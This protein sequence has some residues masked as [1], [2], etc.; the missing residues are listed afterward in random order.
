MTATFDS[1]GNVYSGG[2]AFSTGY[3]ATIGAYQQN[4]AGGIGIGTG[5]YAN[6]CD[7]AIIKYSPD[8]VSRL[9][10]TY[11]GGGNGEEL[12]HSLVCDAFDNLLIFGTTGSNDFPT[13]Q[14]AYD[15]TFNGGT[16]VTYD[17]VILF[18]NGTDIYVS[19]ISEDGTQ[20]IASTYI[21]GSKNDGFNFRPNYA[22]EIMHGNDSL[23]YNYADGARGEVIAD[24]KYNVYVGTCT[25]SNDFPTTQNAFQQ[26]SN[27]K[28]EGIVFKLDQNLSNLIF[29]SY[30]GG[31]QDDAIYSIDVGINDDVY[32]AG[33]TSSQDLYTSSNAYKQTYQGGTTDGFVAHISKFGDQII[34][35][36]YFGS[37]NYDQAYFVRLDKTNNIYITGQTKATGNTLIYNAI[38]NTPNSGQFITKLTNNL[39]TIYWSTVFGTGIGK[40][41]ISITAFAVDICNRIY[42]SGWGRE[43]ALHDG[44]T[45]ASIDGTKNMD[46]TPGAY[47]STTDGQDF[48]IMVMADDASYLDYASFFGEQYT[49]GYSGHDHVDGGTS[50]FDNKGN[51]Y[52]SI[53]ASC[54]GFQDFPTYPNPGV[55]S[56]NNNSS[57]C[58]NAVFRFSFADDFSLADF[59]IPPVGCTPYNV[60]FNN[61][62]TG[63]VHYV[64]D[65]GDGSPLS[66]DINPTHTYTNSGIYLVTL[67][68][69]D[70]SSCNL[71]DTVTKQIQVLSNSTDTITDVSICLNQAQQIG[72]APNGNPNINYTWYPSTGLS[73]TTVANP[74]ANPSDTTTYVLIISNGVCGD[75]LY[76]TVNV[77]KNNVSI[78]A[79][80]D[81]TICKGSQVNLFAESNINSGYYIWST[82]N[83]FNDT[84]NSSLNDS[85]LN[86]SINNQT[87]LYVKINESQCNYTAYDSVLINLYPINAQTSNDTTICLNDTINIWAFNTI[88]NDTLIYNWNGNNII[89][90]N[91]SNTATIN[92][93][94]NTSYILWYQN[95]HG[96]SNTD[97][98]NVNVE[99]IFF[100]NDSIIDNKCYGD[101][102]GEIYVSVSASLPYN[103]NWNNGGSGNYQT[104]LC[105]GNYSLTVSDNIGC[106]DSIN[107]QISQPT[108]IDAQITNIIDASCN[109]LQSNT[110]SAS[111][112]VSGG[113]PGYYY[114]WSDGQNTNTA[115]SLYAGNYSVTVTDNNGCDTILSVYIT[116]Q[117]NLEIQTQSTSALCYGDCNGSAIV[118][119][120]T[121]SLPPYQFNWS[122]GQTSQN[123]N[124]LCSG[125]YQVT[126]IDNNN[127][128]RTNEVFVAQPQQLAANISN[129][130]IICYGDS[131]IVYVQNTTGGNPPYDY[132]WN[133]GTT[134]DSIYTFA[135]SGYV[136]V[137]DTNNCT[138]TTLFNISQPDSIYF[139]TSITDLSCYESCNGMAKINMHGGVPPYTY[140]WS[141][142]TTIDS[143]YNVC[144][145][146]YKLTVSDALG[147][148]NIVNFNIGISSYVPPVN[149]TT[150]NYYIYNGQST[151]LYTN[152][153]YPYYFW[154]PSGSLNTTKQPNVIASPSET[155]TYL[156]KIIDKYGCSNTDTITIFVNDLICNEPYIYVP[157]AFTPN[158][159]GKNDILY[160]YGNIIDD[161][162]FA[163][164]DRW[165][166]LIFVTTDINKGWDGTYKGK[167]EDPAVF[168][169][170]LRATCINKQTFIKKGNITLIR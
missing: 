113:T 22:N 51:I 40:P 155:T 64:W 119:I 3:P 37:N 121:Q 77:I 1:H 92:P 83:Q 140:H 49:T 67:I 105:T 45:W 59:D 65:F 165:G 66:T 117:S 69:S 9:W 126:V 116:D 73:D 11:I 102:N 111:V 71:A 15:T 34:G 76:Q 36:T 159:D 80:N 124:N 138:D 38:Y 6:G 86:I 25:F 147:C 50:R 87:Y 75:T 27:G 61:T 28:Q 58:N 125:Y 136:I 145:G 30:F 42:L 146:N 60:T 128:I 123:I 143:I 17:N 152:T 78:Q 23:Y 55:W 150:D 134:N 169:Y 90:G 79:Y 53:C 166:E 153:N 109:G 94:Q 12:P 96:C 8:G 82:T 167:P 131:C 44:N 107:L 101:C 168:V 170:Y 24:S 154:S 46:I 52:Q 20:L 4:F 137:T 149:I 139:D 54:G 142:G 68:A 95:Q 112:N 162:Y 41:N 114:L 56:N 70:S 103:I 127:C 108:E 120:T 91:N 62:S 29:S 135:G 19:K 2:I 132:I 43:W 161:L 16:D 144:S 88:P 98:V 5:T 33:G 115:D 18:P 35:S 74:Y 110:G 13:T 160:V 156:V 48:Y 81:T 84:L 10:A 148:S 7:V 14:N 93:T 106:N 163:I 118:N 39:D 99:N 21:G 89:Y 158:N 130:N 85:S 63:G 157:N 100:S 97:T 164:Y 133:N 32:V 122:N 57:N 31:S 151:N 72:V 129:T 47:Q 141:T 104:N 26:N